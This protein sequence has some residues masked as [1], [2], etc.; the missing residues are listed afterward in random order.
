M[1]NTPAASAPTHSKPPHPG[2]LMARIRELARQGAYSWGDHVFDRSDEREIDISD[3][4]EVLRLGEID[5]P[6]VA[7]VNTGEWKCKV[8]AKT[9]RS[10]RELGVVL[11]VVRNEKM[12]LITVEWED[13]K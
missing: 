5:G 9:D 8:T 3:A 2:A 12:F 6:I 4:I 1:S 10:S 11:V 7:G 13:P